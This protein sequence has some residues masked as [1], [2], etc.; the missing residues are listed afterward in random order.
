MADHVQILC[1]TQQL[2]CIDTGGAFAEA[3]LF[4]MVARNRLL[5][6]LNRTT[7]P[8]DLID[9]VIGCKPMD[10][11]LSTE[12]MIGRVTALLTA[13]ATKQAFVP[14]HKLW[15]QDLKSLVDATRQQTE[16]EAA[17]AELV[18]RVQDLSKLQNFGA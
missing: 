3:N 6:R 9:A 4:Y 12:E 15:K 13:P 7:T 14:L 17:F 18:S 16:H 8:T 11:G 5:G 2:L 10:L 1:Y